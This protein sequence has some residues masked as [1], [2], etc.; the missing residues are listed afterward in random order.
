MEETLTRNQQKAVTHYKG[1]AIVIAGPGSGKTKVI[2]ERIKFLI[3]NKNVSP[4]KI[5]VTTFTEKASGELKHRLS[6]VLGPLAS[7]V[8]I[9][10]IHSL[11]RYLLELSYPYHDLGVSFSV[12]GNDDQELFI[13]ANKNNWKLMGRMGWREPIRKQYYSNTPEGAVASLYNTMTSNGIT[14]ET[15]IKTLEK[16]DELTH[17]MQR[18]IESFEYYCAFKKR[19]KLIDFDELL[20]KVYDLLKTDK[21]ARTLM[22]ST[23]DYFLFDEYQDT[24]PLQDSIFRTLLTGRENLFVVGDI[25]Q[26]IYGFRGAS[27][28][29]FEDFTRNFPKAKEY[30]LL[31]NFR[32]TRNI[33]TAANNLLEKRLKSELK[34]KREHGD[35][36]VLLHGEDRDESLHLCSSYIKQLKH[37]GIINSYGK[38]AILC[39]TRRMGA[40]FIPFLERENIPYISFSD[41]TFFEQE[42]VRSFIYFLSYIFQNE[43][44]NNY[45]KEWNTWWNVE[46]WAGDVLGLTSSGRKNIRRFT[47]ELPVLLSEDKIKKAGFDKKSDIQKI[48]ALNELRENISNKKIKKSLHE[49]LFEIF[50]ICGYLKMLI[51]KEANS[52]QEKILNIGLLTQLI[53]GYCETMKRP[54]IK[55]LLNFLYDR[56]RQNSI[57]RKQI[58]QIDSLKI[59]TIHK[60]KGL[61]FPL[62]IIP[63]L[64]KNSLPS[65]YREHT[66]CGIKIPKQLLIQQRTTD[67][68]ELHYNEELRLFYVA[69][70][71]AQDGL[72]LLTSQKINT[73]KTEPSPF[74]NLIKDFITEEVDSLQTIV[75]E[76]RIP[77][78]IHQLSYSSLRIYNDCPFRYWLTYEAGI[79]TPE[80]YRQKVGILIHNVLQMINND[81]SAGKAVTS[82]NINQYLKQYWQEITK[83]A[84]KGKKQQELKTRFMDYYKKVKER[85]KTI[86]AVEQPFSH[87]EGKVIIKGKIDLLAVKKNGETEL[88]DFK[89][90]SKKGIE[91]LEISTQLNLYSKCLDRDDITSLAAYAFSDGHFKTIEID[92]DKINSYLNKNIQGIRGNKFPKDLESSFCG[93][94]NCPYEFICKEKKHE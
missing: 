42:E 61:E 22:Q 89:A 10:T 7:L 53:S 45:H 54:Q 47:G 64:T 77:D 28:K 37:K 36:I 15:L 94:D 51:E 38:T 72:I 93:S 50:S 87:I 78:K 39:R 48:K 1:P 3:S 90:S 86:E 23:F 84:D 17:D 4:S 46:E 67:P 19:E 63:G 8:H 26:S 68:K 34:A 2:I 13:N 20:R 41:G 83:P 60:S 59:M 25:D 80:L 76:Y 82:Q 81:I 5:A 73:N 79:R 69:I 9:S 49:A 32:S 57:N 31:T 18:V 52:S 62:V 74:L 91:L 75:A 65:Q 88:I 55:G 40:A 58:E 92:P 24:D 16:T 44:N 30:H 56:S 11:C 21:L 71:R 6:K 35:P 27:I 33:V 70:T 12:L 43:I 85:Y 14:S 66:V 29:N